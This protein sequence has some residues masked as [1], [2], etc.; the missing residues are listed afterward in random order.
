MLKPLDDESY[1]QLALNL[2]EQTSGQTGTNP[3][4]GCI[5]V[6][7]GRMIGIGA[8]LRQG[9]A[10]A[11][12]NALEMAGTESVGSTVYVTLE[13]CSHYGK[14]PPC[15]D[16]L[17][18]AGVKRVVM[19]CE[20]PDQR[21]A[22]RGKEKLAAAGIAVTVGVLKEQAEEVNR[23]YFKVRRTNTPYVT[24]KTASTL[25]G[26]IASRTGDSRWIT[27][28]QS[29]SFVHGLRHRHQAIMVGSETV[30]K[31]N[32]RLTT[33][34]KV[35]G[36]NPVRLVVSTTLHQLPH[37]SFIFHDQ[38]APT[39]ILTTE[40]ASLE[41]ANQFSQLGIEVIRCGNGKFVD[42]RI[43]M[44]QLMERHI[45]SILLEGGG[46]LNGSMLQERLVDEVVLFFAP[47]IIGGQMSPSS[48]QFDGFPS[49]KEAIRLSSIQMK[50]FGDDFCVIGKPIYPR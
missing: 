30:R 24:L 42:M 12:V 21:V 6:K 13:P 35:E 48:F 14:T 28:E 31:D 16:Q 9:G 5:L 3:V 25:D 15:A 43:A 50:T 11:E 26:R 45:H 4:V 8:H 39:M 22:G 34:M 41:A 10:H 38:S 2:A 17:I 23:M 40:R 33:R 18:Q 46:Q 29:R 36:L 7:E 49:M 37:E 32:P 47:K 20:D 27:N 44:K 1:M 19:A